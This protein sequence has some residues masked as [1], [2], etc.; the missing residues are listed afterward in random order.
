MIHS[1]PPSA[2]AQKLSVADI[3]AKAEFFQGTCLAL[4][5][6]RDLR[7]AVSVI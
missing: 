2:A 5:A 6:G 4:R 7:T 1:F 3:S